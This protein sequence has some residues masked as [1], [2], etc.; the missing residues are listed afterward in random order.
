MIG[1][2]KVLAPIYEDAARSLKGTL[3]LAKIDA[4]SETA[5]A[6]RFGI[7]GFPHLKFLREGEIKNYNGARTQE[8]IVAFGKEMNQPAVTI[9]NKLEEYKKLSEKYPVSAVFFGNKNGAERVS[10]HTY[11]CMQYCYC[12]ESLI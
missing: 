1:H 10:L 12:T 5:L 4:T 7:K 3:N 11:G 6:K 2:C 9:I 8:G